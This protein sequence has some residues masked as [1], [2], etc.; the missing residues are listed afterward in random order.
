MTADEIDG[1]LSEMSIAQMID[2]HR[3]LTMG[4]AALASAEKAGFA[5]TASLI[6]DE[7]GAAITIS[8]EG[9]A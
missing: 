4:V 9:G 5:G 3:V 2:L 7:D 1:C 6:G 8:V